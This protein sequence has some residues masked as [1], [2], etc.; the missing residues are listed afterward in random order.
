MTVIYYKVE[1]VGKFVHTD[2]HHTRS[3]GPG[4]RRLTRTSIVHGNEKIIGSNPIVSSEYVFAVQ[5]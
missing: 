4:V 5:S 2:E 3:H 1:N